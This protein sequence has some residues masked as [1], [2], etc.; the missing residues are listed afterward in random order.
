METSRF[1]AVATV[2]TFSLDFSNHDV[3]LRLSCPLSQALMPQASNWPGRPLPNFCRHQ[4]CEQTKGTVHRY[5][6]TFAA[7]SVLRVFIA[8]SLAADELSDCVISS[9]PIVVISELFR[10]ENLIKVFLLCACFSDAVTS[11]GGY[12]SNG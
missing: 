7:F 8:E 3:R 2:T 4:T 10:S 12:A 9:D 5:R 6:N 11:N 1:L